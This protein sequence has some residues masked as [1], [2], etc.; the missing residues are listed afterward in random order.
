MGPFAATFFISM[1]MLVMQFLWKYIDDLMGKGLETSIIIELLFY[2]SASLLPLALPLAILLSSLIVMGNLGETNELTALK[3]S[4]L[5]IYRILRPLTVIVV[6][7]AL[8]TFYF[9]N[10]V[11]PRA[12]YKWHSIIWDIQE[13]KMTSFLTPG[14]YTQE[15]DGFSIKIGKGTDNSFQDIIIHDRRD[16]EV[17]K[18]IV[19]D[20]GEFFR[21]TSGD[22]LFFKLYDGNVIEELKA[23]PSFMDDDKKL[24][25]RTF[26]SRKSFFRTATYKMDISGFELKRSRE[27]LFKDDYEMLNV[28][29]INKTVDSLQKNF[30]ELS[31][32]LSFSTKSKHEYFQA[33]N[34]AKELK[35]DSLIRLKDSIQPFQNPEKRDSLLAQKARNAKNS[36][37]GK[38]ML[39][40]TSNMSKD[41]SI[42]AYVHLKAQLR[43]KINSLESQIKMEESRYKSLRKF[44]IEFH[45]KFSLSFTIIVLF[46]IGA[47][48]GAIVKRGGFGAPV[49]IAALLFMIYFVLISIG[50]SM[51]Q[52]EILPPY[53]GMWG[54]SI[55]LLPFA[56]FLLISAANDKSVVEMPRIFRRKKKKS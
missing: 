21:S 32:S 26:P 34:Y 43:T 47:P 33:I 46:F 8:G 20:S 16:Q 56:I 49:V 51:A 30:K 7:I 54:P 38:I 11:I 44:E 28:F 27:D 6:L 23:S 18:T 4:G 52:S 14:S 24:N 13:K 15:I 40:H 29:Q 2:V 17:L 36:E 25:K 31:K 39:F 10:Y 42:K 50:D 9:S 1:F 12:N 22:Y 48:L 3:S 37:S 45:R 19:A 41:D 35:N 55:V 5:S 53:L